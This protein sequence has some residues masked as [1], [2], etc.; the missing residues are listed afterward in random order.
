[1]KVAI[2]G[3]GYVGLPL[4]MQFARAGLLLSDS[5]YW[6]GY[7]PG[8]VRVIQVDTVAPRKALG[9]SRYPK[10]TLLR[11]VSS[12]PKRPARLSGQH[13]STHYKQM[14]LPS[15]TATPRTPSKTLQDSR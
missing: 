8:A 15:R 5:L 13:W 10:H 9:I 6:I 4:A 12:T 14:K 2:V 11:I 7:R 3:L 1:M